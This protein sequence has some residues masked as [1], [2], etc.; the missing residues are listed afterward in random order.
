L[1]KARDADR[2]PG[3]EPG[4]EEKGKTTAPASDGLNAAAVAGTGSVVAV[5]LA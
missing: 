2:L 5:E 4:A 3:L 1:I